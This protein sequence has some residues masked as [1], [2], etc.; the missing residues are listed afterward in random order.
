ME[1]GDKLRKIRKENKLTLKELSI[2]TGVS[3]SFISD[4]ENKRRNPS[5][6]TLKILAKALGVSV[7]IFWDDNSIHE[8]IETIDD[9]VKIL[10]KKIKK[11][12]KENRKK[13][14]KMLDI[15]LNE[16]N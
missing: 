1:I 6:D 7:S 9:D 2:K 16:N 8:E 3:I 10:V 4:I 15:F 14:L 12:S 13:A 5:I 11:M